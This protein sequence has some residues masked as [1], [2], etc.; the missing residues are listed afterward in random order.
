MQVWLK[1]RTG[2]EVCSLKDLKR[3]GASG[4][5]WFGLTP[6]NS[7]LMLRATGTQEIYEL[8]WHDH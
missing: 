8:N 5:F 4:G 3:T 6:E 7:P 1:D 2:R